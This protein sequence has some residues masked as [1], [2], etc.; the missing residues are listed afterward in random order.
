[1]VIDCIVN[2]ENKVLEQKHG[3]SFKTYLIGVATARR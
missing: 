1:M 2:P 3:S